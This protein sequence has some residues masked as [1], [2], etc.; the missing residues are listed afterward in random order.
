M[1]SKDQTSSYHMTIMCDNCSIPR[2]VPLGGQAT[3]LAINVA[4]WLL[5]TK[6]IVRG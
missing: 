5:V 2:Y 1:A 4:G 3:S 6:G